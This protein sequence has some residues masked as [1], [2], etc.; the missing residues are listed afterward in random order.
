MACTQPSR[1]VADPEGRLDWSL[2][3]SMP[4]LPDGHGL[5]LVP[6]RTCLGCARSTQREWA[7]RCY[8][9]SLFHYKHWRDP[10]SGVTTE[11]PNSCALTLTYSD[12]HLPEHG[13]LD[14][15]ALRRFFKRLR[16]RRGVKSI[17]HFS[18]G[19][20]G[21]KSG[22]PHY[23]VLLFGETFDDRYA[24]V[25]SDGQELSCS[26]ELD[27]LWAECDGSV[28]DQIGRAS[29]DDVNFQTISYVAGYV[30]KKSNVEGFT[31]P[32]GELVDL[33]TGNVQ[34][35]SLSPEFR[36]MSTKPGLGKDYL[37]SHWESLY[38]DDCV[39]IGSLKFPTPTYYDRWLKKEHP[40]TWVSVQER[41]LEKRFEA[42]HEWD[43]NR[44]NS[45]AAINSS[46]SRLDSL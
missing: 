16:N 25:T 6:C 3:P 38:T 32:I 37:E 29:I 46:L 27:E 26:Y 17:R 4:D 8:H 7:I 22:R 19:E 33:V 5:V 39:R 13:L 18:A 23:H 20:Y 31:G 1:V 11:V 21:G 24:F 28:R 45:R 14:K 34:F 41:R 12:A 30:A 9:E 36:T 35:K 44:L 43:R 42:Y 15:D 2:N 40:M 10:D